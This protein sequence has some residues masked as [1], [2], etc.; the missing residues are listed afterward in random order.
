M[1]F[2]LC[3]LFLS[4]LLGF[5]IK[6]VNFYLFRRTCDYFSMSFHFLVHPYHTSLDCLSKWFFFFAFSPVFFYVLGFMFLIKVVNFYLFLRTCDY[7]SIYFNFLCAYVPYLY[8]KGIPLFNFPRF[9]SYFIFIS[10]FDFILL[11]WPLPHFLFCKILT[12]Q[13]F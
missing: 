10:I 8:I 12:F 11:L 4:L 7:F 5:L 2:V 3:F 13:K 6:V 9:F 1:F